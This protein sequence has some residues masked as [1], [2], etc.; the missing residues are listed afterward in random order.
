MADEVTAV[1]SLIRTIDWCECIV[2]ERSTNLGL[3][4]SV[5]LGA[6]TVLQK[7]PSAIFFEDDLISV[8]GTYRYMTSALRHYEKN[9]KVMSITGWTH[10]RIIP[11]DVGTM[12][13]FDGK[14]EGWAWAL[15]LECG[16][17]WK[18]QRSQ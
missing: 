3:G 15:G 6:T 10:P 12:P 5:K 18:I 1:R 4:V 14:A 7:Y 8:P 13:Y 11:D 17:G 16:K 2:E 9:H